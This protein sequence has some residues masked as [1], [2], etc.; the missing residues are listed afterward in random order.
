M[1]KMTKII[2]VLIFCFIAFSCKKSSDNLT[3]PTN[4]IPT[5][6]LIAYYPFNGNA[7]DESSNGHNGTVNGATLTTD[8]FGNTNK[9]YNFSSNYIELSNTEDINFL[10]G[11]FTLSA[12][13][14]FSTFVNDGLLIAKHIIGS[15]SDNG[16]FLNVWANKFAF[17]I[18]MPRLTTTQQ[19]SDGH[20]HHIVGIYD[21]TTEYIYV[22]GIQNIYKTV[23]GPIANSENIRIGTGGGPNYN[24]S[25]FEGKIDDI[26]IYNRSLSTQEILS[27]YH[28]GG[29]TK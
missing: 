24:T 10:S 19:Y 2:C 5:A 11:G 18:I 4:N 8:R 27:L 1:K 21:G 23:S 7:N 3:T 14:N 9:A 16:Y 6:G 29:W 15:S 17:G 22:D 26:R 12:W 28:E 20:W 25:Y 13:V